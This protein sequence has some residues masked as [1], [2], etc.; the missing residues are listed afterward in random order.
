[1]TLK[2][3]FDFSTCAD[4]EGW[5]NLRMSTHFQMSKTVAYLYVYPSTVQLWARIDYLIHSLCYRSWS[6]ASCIWLFIAMLGFGRS[7]NSIT[8]IANKIQLITQNNWNMMADVDATATARGGLALGSKRVSWQRPYVEG[9]SNM[10]LT[11]RKT[12]ALICW[13]HVVDLITCELEL[14]KHDSHVFF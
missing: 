12:I 10:D 3:D 4:E 2:N 13:T 8:V 9:K 14:I 6:S 7:Q 5:I 11:A 1:M